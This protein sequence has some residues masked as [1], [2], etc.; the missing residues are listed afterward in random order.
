MS[1]V[2]AFQIGVWNAWILT[3]AYSMVPPL[4][5]A[6][7]NREA[8]KKS[9]RPSLSG[10]LKKI[11]TCITAI[12]FIA[13]LYSVFLPLRLGE[14]WFYAGL[15]VYLIG[16]VMYIIAWVNF[17]TAPLDEPVFNGLYRYSRHP[18]YLSQFLVLIGVG[19]AAAA[20]LF[21]L[22]AI[23]YTTFSLFRAIH[24][25]GLCLEK[26]GEAYREYMNRTPRWIGTLKSRGS[27]RQATYE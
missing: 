16:L 2:P 6:L 26:Y 22:F 1:L 12:Y 20:W 17:D 23:V 27:D 14:A 4:L 11:Y 7:I 21:L 13:L 5:M 10:T 25:E 19:I 15:A 8:L 24:E 3:L 18:M 9:E